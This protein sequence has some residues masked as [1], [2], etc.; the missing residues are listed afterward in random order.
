[1]FVDVVDLTGSVSGNMELDSSIFG[2]S[3]NPIVISDV[4][5]WQQCKRMS[6][7]HSSKGISDISGTT[8]KPYRQKG[9]GRARHGSTRSPQF[10]GGAVIFGPVVRSHSF[11]INKKIRRL[12]LLMSLSL[13]YSSS[14]LAVLDDASPAFS[15]EDCKYIFKTI[16]SSI[17]SFSVSSILLLGDYS[18][19][20]KKSC[21]SL[22]GFDVLPIAG[23][24]VY[25][26]ISSDLLLIGKSHYQKLQDRLL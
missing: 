15:S 3:C 10:R 13:K 24:N 20:L 19:I 6:G 5:R 12:A 25:D 18:D 26:I 17:G 23:A 11:A 7:T 2:F 16:K 1:M 9:T 4:I 21:R 14:K 8:K 22:H